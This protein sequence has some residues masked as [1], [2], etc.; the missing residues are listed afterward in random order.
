MKER[1]KL[2]NK[3]WW[4]VIATLGCTALIF[5]VPEIANAAWDNVVASFVGAFVAVGI[6]ILGKLLVVLIYLVVWVAQY[7]DF[8]ASPAVAIGWT[9]VRDVCNMF[10]ILILLIIAFA[11]IFNVEKYSWKHLL[12]KLLIMAVLINFSKLICGLIIDFAQVIML[13]FVNGFRDIAG[14]NFGSMFGINELLNISGQ[15]GDVDLLSVAGTYVLAVLYVLVALV[16]ITV[17]LFVLVIRIVMLWILVVLSPLVYL[18]SSTPSTEGYA[19][20]WWKQFINNVVAG[21]VLAF[22]I[23]LSFA[24]MQNNSA[25]GIFGTKPNQGSDAQYYTE[26]SGLAEKAQPIAGLAT[27]GT[28]EGMLKFII[29]I[30]LLIGGLMITKQIGGA[31]GD[32]AGKGIGTISKGAASLSG[33]NAV[34]DRLNAFNKQREAAHSAKMGEFGAKWYGRYSSVQ[35][36]V[37][38][39]IQGLK[40]GAKGAVTQVGTSTLNRMSRSQNGT[41]R[42]VAAGVRGFNQGMKDY[43]QDKAKRKEEKRE[44]RNRMRDA[45]V[46]RVYTDEH[47]TKYEERQHNGKTVYYNAQKQEFAKKDGEV[48]TKMSTTRYNADRAWTKAMV[49]SR[50]Y[51]NKNNKEKIEKEKDKMVNA[52]MSP[53]QLLGVLEDSAASTT[54]KM[55]AALSLAVKEGFKNGGQVKNAQTILKNLNNPLL[56]KQFNDDIDKKQAHLNYDLTTDIG[57]K[58]FSKRRE[59]GKFDVLQADAYK[60]ANVIRALSDSMTDKEFIKHMDKISAYSSKHNEAQE[61]GLR[62][63][64]DHQTPAIDPVTGKV[65]KARKATPKITHDLNDS[66]RGIDNARETAEVLEQ[67]MRDLSLGDIAKLKIESLTP[68]AN[69][70]TQVQAQYRNT[71]TRIIQGFDDAEIESMKKNKDANRDTVAEIE[72]IRNTGNMNTNQNNPGNTP[73]PPRNQANNQRRNRPNPPPPPSGNQGNTPPNNNQRGNT[74]NTPWGNVNEE[75]IQDAQFTDLTDEDDNEEENN[76]PRLLNP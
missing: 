7:N 52:G 50:S 15:S 29:S 25:E 31:A 54:T 33:Y 42:G 59:E 34:K 75:D 10:F 76:G 44:H 74:R 49:D 14:G 53:A 12:P 22:F 48:I 60:D 41:V 64:L 72:R 18:L 6:W 66:V 63:Y 30:G 17:I 40:A 5:L 23:W 19:K 13:T 20:D 2:G 21:P 16:V 26:F 56:T 61:Q 36:G 24:T 58:K 51:N 68:N 38:G 27:A 9:I 8:I 3:K 1:K 47:G 32:I 4:S 67:V 46:N 65:H 71:L 55:A 35:G 43:V 37:K 69:L 73:P 11:T 28:P 57:R 62:T 45:Y 70:P 39:S